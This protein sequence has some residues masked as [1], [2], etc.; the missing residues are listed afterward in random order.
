M[1][2][3]KIQ[4]V[5]SGDGKAKLLVIGDPGSGKTRL[6]GTADSALIIRPSM[7]HTES[8]GDPGSRKIDEWVIDNWD[9]MN[10]AYEYARHDAAKEYEW[11]WLDSISLWQDSG[12]DDIFEDAVARKPT[13]ANAG[14]DKPEYGTNMYRLQSWVRHM[15]Q[16]PFHFGITAHPFRYEDSE[17]DELIMPW[18]QGRNMP[19]KICGYMNIVSHLV[20]REKEGQTRKILITEKRGKWYAK[21]QLGISKSGKISNPTLPKITKALEKKGQQNG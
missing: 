10:E 21:D 7:D 1:A 15:M 18:I 4:R 3:D 9:E 16:L 12:L 2:K 6:I 8:I 11:V 5:G 19:E 20:V 14:P 17:G 13:R